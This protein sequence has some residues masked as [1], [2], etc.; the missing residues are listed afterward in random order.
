MSV[1][2]G[3]IKWFK[4]RKIHKLCD[5]WRAAMRELG[6][7]PSVTELTDDALLVGLKDLV[8]KENPGASA[9]QLVS[10]ALWTLEA[11]VIAAETR[12]EEARS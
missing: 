9:E 4:G 5:R 2:I 12:L 10:G 7:P 8:H 11:S 1:L 3:P 6:E